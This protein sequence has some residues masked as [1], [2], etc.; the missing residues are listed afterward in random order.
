MFTICCSSGQETYCYQ[1]ILEKDERIVLPTTQQL[2]S[3]S[4]LQ[5]D[6]KLTEVSIGQGQT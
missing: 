4:F 2:L 3:L 6:M 1:V 5:S